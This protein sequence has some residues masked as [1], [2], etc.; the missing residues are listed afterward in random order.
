MRWG[1]GSRW[2]SC[3]ATWSWRAGPAR[4]GGHISTGC[5]RWRTGNTSGRS[6]ATERRWR[7][8]TARCGRG[9]PSWPGRS[10]SRWPLPAPGSSPRGNRGPGTSASGSPPSST[11]WASGAGVAALPWV[12]RA[13]GPGG[14]G[15]GAGRSTDGGPGAGHVHGGPAPR[16]PP[17]RDRRRSVRGYGSTGQQRS[18]AV[19]LKLV[20]LVTLRE[21]RGTEPALLLDDVFAELDDERRERLA[22]RLVGRR[23]PAGVSHGAARRRAAQGTGAGGVDGARRQSGGAGGMS[24]IRKPSPIADALASYLRRSGF[25]KRIQQ[26]GVIEAW[27]ELVGP[28]DRRRDRTGF[29]DPRRRAA[30]PGHHRGL[31]HRARADDAPDPGPDQRRPAGTGEG[32]TL[33]ARSSRS[34]EPLM[35]LR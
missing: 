13:G 5:S 6:R 12:A 17:A 11:A 14:M 29:G 21:A 26:A 3:R 8:G 4:C 30:R 31:G 10:T 2:C 1:A 34:S 9:G 23:G 7:S 28:A 19:A 16:R 24:E 20:E 33:G 32:D 22:A 27:P 15:R 25:S 35:T 18:A